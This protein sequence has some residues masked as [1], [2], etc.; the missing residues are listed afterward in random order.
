MFVFILSTAGRNESKFPKRKKDHSAADRLFAMNL[1]LSFYTPEEH[2]LNE[3]DRGKVWI[4]P[5]F[6]P[7]ILDDTINLIEPAD[8]KITS[9]IQEIIIL[10]GFPASGKSFFCKKYMKSAGYEIVN[11]DTLS[12]QQKC[13]AAIDA[14]LKRGKSCVIDNT[15]PD[16]SSRKR[17]IDE[18]RKFN[19]PIRCFFFTTTY[20]QSR[21]NNKFRELTDSSHA[22]IHDMIFHVYKNKFVEPTTKEGFSEIV[23]VNFLPKFDKNE[24]KTLYNMYLLER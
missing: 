2:F 9:D 7:T 4:K 18:A 17:Y 13:L 10:V 16:I 15:N 24:H 3:K 14:A 1:N 19:I 5:A 23:K 8:A 20:E 11:R 21:H 22:K 6:N 12:T